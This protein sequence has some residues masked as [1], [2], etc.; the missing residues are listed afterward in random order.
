MQYQ[1][2]R[3]KCED[4]DEEALAQEEISEMFPSYSDSDFAEFKPPTLEQRKDKPRNIKP[5]LLLSPDDVSLIY[6][7]HSNFVRNLTNAQWLSSPKKLVANDVVTPLLLRYPTFS[8]VIQG[9]WETLDVTFEGTILPSLMV[10]VSHIKNK[11]DGIGECLKYANFI[12]GGYFLNT[13]LSEISIQMENI[14]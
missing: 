13:Q 14:K 5:K 7:W 11:V 4:E 9:A 8:R 3:S 2:S 12:A 10:L 6:R 1:C